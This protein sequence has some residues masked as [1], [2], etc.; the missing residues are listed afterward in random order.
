MLSNRICVIY[1]RLNTRS[2]TP[3]PSLM[4]APL[5]FRHRT[6]VGARRVAIGGVFA[7]RVPP[8]TLPASARRS[9]A[10]RSRVHIAAGLQARHQQRDELRLDQPALVMTRLVPRIGEVDVHAVEAFRRDHVFEHFDG[11]VLDD[12]DIRESCSP[13]SFSNAP[14]PGS[15]T[16][17]PRKSS[18]GRVRRDFRGRRAHAE[19]DFQHARRA[20]AEHGVPVGL[21]RREP[22]HETRAEFVERAALARS[23]RG[24][25]A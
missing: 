6:I 18:A 12:A 25:R 20:A 2:H 1:R 8:T 23:R 9:S 11:V 15:C 19:A 22:E 3:C 10:S 17:T 24:P 13:I 5:E 4:P 7:A 14:T 21:L 16:S